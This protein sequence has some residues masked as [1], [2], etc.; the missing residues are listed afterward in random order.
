[1]T[2]LERLK[3]ALHPEKNINI[4][5][6]CEIIAEALSEDGDY[7]ENREGLAIYLEISPNKVYK[8]LR[9]NR[10][11]IPEAKEWF[12][13]TEYQVNTAY[14]VAALDILAQDSWLRG[15]RTLES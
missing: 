11:M 1:M 9:I 10:D 5:E 12:R 15:M 3:K 2:E 8:M 13:G 7:Y 14:D 4:I 6:Q